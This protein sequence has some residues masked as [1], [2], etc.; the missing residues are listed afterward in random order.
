MRCPVCCSSTSK[1]SNS[2]PIPCSEKK[3]GSIGMSASV[4]AWRALKVSRAD[5]GWAV[6]DNVVVA[7]IEPAEC[8]GED[9]FAA[10]E[11]G[12]RLGNGAQEDVG[13]CQVEVLLHRAR[14]IRDGDLAAA[15]SAP[16]DV[17]HRSGGRSDG[18]AQGGMTL[19]VQVHQ[20]RSSSG[21]RE[22]S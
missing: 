12:K 19:R 16:E 8:P 13:G 5:V 14:D 10:G 6:D 11:P 20:Q 17:V 1:V 2:F 15:V 4:Q 22:E 3:L 18:E 9:V 7:V 21:H